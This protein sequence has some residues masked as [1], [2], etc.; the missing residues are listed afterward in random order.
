MGSDNQ[1][2]RHYSAVKQPRSRTSTCCRYDSSYVA[3][4]TTRTAS[5]K[6]GATTHLRNFFSH[7]KRA[8]RFVVSADRN[9]DPAEAFDEA[10]NR[11][12]DILL[13]SDV[14]EEALDLETFR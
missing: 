2:C 8:I 3:S 1:G 7:H 10:I 4:T 12:I 9:I 13:H 11:A 6:S 5:E 14:A